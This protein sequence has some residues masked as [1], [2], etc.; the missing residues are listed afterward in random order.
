MLDDAG[1]SNATSFGGVMKTPTLDRI[2]DEGIR[3]T[4]MSVA[5]VC[6]PTRGSL[7]TGYNIHQIGTGIIS[8][9]ATGYP[10]YNSQIDYTTP[11]IAKILTDNGYATAAFG[12]WHNTPME[13]ASPA[14]PFESWP[15]GIWGFEYFWGFL[16]GETNQFHPLLYEN[17]TA[18]D[19]PETNADGSEFHLSHGMADQA[20]KWLDN[21]K[22]CET[23][24]S[25]CTTHRVLFMRPFRYLK[26]GAINTKDSL[27]MAGMPT[28]SNSWSVRKNWAWFPKMPSWSTGR[29]SIPTWDSFSE[30]GKRYLSRQ[31]EVNAAFLEHVD[32]HVGRVIDHIEEMGELDNTLVI[33]LSADNGCYGR[34]NP[35]R[36]LLRAVDAER[37]ST[38]DHGTA[39][40]KT[41]RVRRSGCLGWP[42][43]GQPFFGGL[44]LRILHT[45]PVD[46]ADGVPFRR[47][48]VRYGHTIPESH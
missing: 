1:Y 48:H 21:G 36:N 37:V 33:Y 17:T 39:A 41:R 19:T 14:G 11:S 38:P 25:S 8:E 10:G 22:D 24:R 28:G 27:T 13:E 6:S 46:Q 34:R 2:G 3:Y 23:L 31:M 43:Y 12:K 42:S 32:H 16:G 9:M 47:N 26:S 35:D 44:G 18:I 45:V 29:K 15:T 30:E 5:A 7:L 40:G 20:I 4:H